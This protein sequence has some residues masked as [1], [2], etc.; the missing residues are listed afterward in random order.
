VAQDPLREANLLDTLR[1]S[2]VPAIANDASGRLVFWNRAAEAL[3]QRSAGKALPKRCFEA[4]PGRDVFGNRYCSESCPVLDMARR[5]EPVRAFGLLVKTPDMAREEDLHVTVLKLPG[6]RP[7]RFLLV[8]LLQP[9]RP[10]RRSIAP[11]SP[12][13]AC[14]AELHA[15]GNGNGNGNGTGTPADGSPEHH[16]LTPREVEVLGWVSAG[17]QNKEIAQRLSISLA[18][19]RNHVHNILEKLEV[20]SKLEAVSLAFRRGWISS[21]ASA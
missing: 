5:Q 21:S 9:A 6:S 2:D 15:N 1:A 19:V 3:F 7:D 12:R 17:L 20:H 14:P 8:H 13:I 16:G 10:E 4:I 11:S 18:T